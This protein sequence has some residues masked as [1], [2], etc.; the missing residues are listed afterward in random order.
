MKKMTLSLTAVFIAVALLMTSCG[1][2][3]SSTSGGGTVTFTGNGTNYSYPANDGMLGITAANTNRVSSADATAGT[4]NQLILSTPHASGTYSWSA[5][6]YGASIELLKNGS[7]LYYTYNA[8]GASNG[9]VTVTISGN[10]ATATFNGTVYNL[11]NASDSVVIT[12][13]HFSGKYYTS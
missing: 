4:N 2:T 10:T 8:N 13:G 6:G 5:S 11:T 1:K 7:T 3:N 12:N 9:S